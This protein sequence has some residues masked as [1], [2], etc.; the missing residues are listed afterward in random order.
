MHNH[1]HQP[2]SSYSQNLD[3][4]IR[5]FRHP[6]DGDERPG[7][8]PG[9]PPDWSLEINGLNLFELGIPSLVSP[10]FCR[11]LLGGCD[12]DVVWAAD[13]WAPSDI[14]DPVTVRLVAFDFC[15]HLRLRVII[16]DLELPIAASR[17]QSLHWLVRRRE[18]LLLEKY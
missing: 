8:I 10:E 13:V 16:P 3:A 6:R 11:A 1:H 14:A 9:T 2:Y 12:N 15:K 4:A 7:E 5:V 18:L 17:G